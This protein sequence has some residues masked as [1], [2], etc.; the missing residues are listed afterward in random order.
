MVFS[1]IFRPRLPFFRRPEHRQRILSS[2]RQLLR[3]AQKFTDP[4]EQTYLRDAQWALLTMRGALAGSADQQK[5]IGD[6][7][8]GRTGW[9]KD[10]MQQVYEFHHPTQSCK[11]IRDVRPR[12]SQIHQPHRAYWIPLDLRA[13]SVPPHL[14]QRI[15]DEDIN[16]GNPF[17]WD[18]GLVP[19][20]F[21][22][23]P[24]VSRGPSYVPGGCE[25]YRV[26]ARKPPH[27]LSAKIASTYQRAASRVQRHEFY[28]YFIEDLLLEEE[29]EE[30]LGVEDRGYWIFARNYRD[31]LRTRIKNF[32]LQPETPD[33]MNE[34]VEVL[35]REY[36]DE[37]SRLVAHAMEPQFRDEMN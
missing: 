27:W 29:F 11:L 28:Y 14:L 22:V 26:N 31:F 8:Y 10:V 7:A 18:G 24:S 4:I 25:F 9:L 6:L 32:S 20:A 15:A 19:G 13:F 21:S 34:E 33:V 16:A 35:M 3:H 30:R 12:S 36:E 17:L 23:E 2:Y 1:S 5:Y 37:Y